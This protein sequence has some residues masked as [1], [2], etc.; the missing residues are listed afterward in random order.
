MFT[1]IEIKQNYTLYNPNSFKALKKIQILLTKQ[2]NIHCEIII[3]KPRNYLIFA[4]Q[5]NKNNLK[6]KT[7]KQLKNHL[8][9]Q[10]D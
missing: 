5:R 8:E 1:F 2:T 10:Q 4:A 3:N 9:I 7:W 6:N